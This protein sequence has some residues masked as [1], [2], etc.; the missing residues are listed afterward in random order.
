MKRLTMALALAGP[1]LMSSCVNVRP[2]NEHVP[3]V[4]STTT[5]ETS[6]RS[7]PTTPTVETQNVR[8][9]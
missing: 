1:L 6:V 4:T 7:R 9:Y 3:Q 2:Q 8:S 5:Q